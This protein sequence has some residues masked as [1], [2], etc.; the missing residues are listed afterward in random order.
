MLEHSSPFGSVYVGVGAALLEAAAGQPQCVAVAA[1][2]AV[3]SA[4]AA[5]STT[6]VKKDLYMVHISQ[7]G[8]GTSTHVLLPLICSAY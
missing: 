3:M 1:E 7:P 4:S 5:A 8:Q 2:H 6:A